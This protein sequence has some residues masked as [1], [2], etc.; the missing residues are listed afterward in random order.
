MSEKIVIGSSV[1]NAESNIEVYHIPKLRLSSELGKAALD[2]ATATLIESGSVPGV[3][4][5][6]EIVSG[7]PIKGQRDRSVVVLDVYKGGSLDTV[8]GTDQY[9]EKQESIANI[10]RSEH[11]LNNPN[12]MQD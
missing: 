11:A 7:A 12:K 4:P 8:P 1:N 3:T 9:A 6:A 10:A 2:N 5:S